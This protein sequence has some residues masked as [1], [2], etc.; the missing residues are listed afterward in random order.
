[1]QELAHVAL[2]HLDHAHINGLQ[3]HGLEGE[4]QAIGAGQDG[5]L[6]V[7]AHGGLEFLEHQFHAHLFAKRAA[8][9]VAQAGAHV[10][11][12][13]ACEPLGGIEHEL[14]AIVRD[15]QVVGAGNAHEAAQVLSGVQRIAEEQR[16]VLLAIA[17]GGGA[18]QR[19]IADGRHIE[20]Q[21]GGVGATDALAIPADVH[22]RGC[23]A[24]LHA[25]HREAVIAAV[26]LMLPG[27]RQI[28]AFLLRGE[29]AFEVL[30]GGIVAGV[31]AGDEPLPLQVGGAQRLHLVHACIDALLEG[32]HLEAEVLQSLGHLDQ[33]AEPEAHRV[34]LVLL[35]SFIGNEGQGELIAHLHAALH[36]GREVEELLQ[37]RGR[38]IAPALPRSDAHDDGRAR[39]DV[40]AGEGGDVG[41]EGGIGLGA[42]LVVATGRKHESAK[43][44]EAERTRKARHGGH[45]GVKSVVKVAVRVPRRTRVSSGATVAVNALLRKLKD[46]AAR[47]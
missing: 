32:A 28:A 4:E 42:L 21:G 11:V 9:H 30:A 3:V 23:I 20:G 44:G 41:R 26:G 36:A 2:V 46:S 45:G 14:V 5:A 38:A 18:D 17:E 43:H 7:E 12:L 37:G 1:M 29:A 47:W 33:V 40:P 31:H 35:Q 27:E 15:A 16:G 8:V 39:A 25:V 10:T 19:E 22:A 34:G 24:A 6:A 13:F